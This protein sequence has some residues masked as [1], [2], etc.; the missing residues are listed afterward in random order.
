MMLSLLLLLQVLDGSMEVSSLD[1]EEE[2]QLLQVSNTI[3]C[4]LK[5]LTGHVTPAS[6]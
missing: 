2:T 4:R 6:T 1:A 3:W 5:I